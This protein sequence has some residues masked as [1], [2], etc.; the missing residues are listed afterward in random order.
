MAFSRHFAGHPDTPRDAVHGARD[1]ES[2]EIAPARTQT[3]LFG[4]IDEV[5]IASP[6]PGSTL[7][8]AT[9]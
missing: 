7:I 1:V 5:E 2:G 9:A 4:A 6:K 8:R 3:E